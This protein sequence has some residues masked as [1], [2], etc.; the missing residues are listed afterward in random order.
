MKDDYK[1]VNTL[2]YNCI[3]IKNPNYTSL[4]NFCTLPISKMLSL[5][6]LSYMPMDL[7]AHV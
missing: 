2:E 1:M 5:F 6:G 4:V 7:A 3:T